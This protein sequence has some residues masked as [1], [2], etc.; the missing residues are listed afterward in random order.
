MINPGTV[1][2]DDADEQL[3]EQ[4]LDVFLTAA[5]DRGAPLAG[6]PV[7]DPSADRDGRFGWDLPMAGGSVTR[8]LMP[9]V[10]LMRVRD[11]LTVDAPCLYVN[12]GAW[13]WPS[14]L[15]MVATAARWSATPRPAELPA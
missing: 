14:A 5:R 1:A 11:D 2:V 7:R 4:N 9:G 13:W 15:G 10:E 6:D 8:L 12:G 3:A